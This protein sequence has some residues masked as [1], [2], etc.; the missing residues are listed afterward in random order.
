MASTQDWFEKATAFEKEDRLIGPTS[1]PLKRQR[2]G[3]DFALSTQRDEFDITR[4][5]QLCRLGLRQCEHQRC[6]QQ[7]KA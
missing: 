2:G 5:I 3:E 1:M 4:L 7:E 6:R